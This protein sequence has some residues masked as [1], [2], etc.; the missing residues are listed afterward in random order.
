[1]CRHFFQRLR[2]VD[3]GPPQSSGWRVCLRDPMR[4]PRSIPFLLQRSKAGKD[5]HQKEFF[6]EKQKRK[7]GSR[8]KRCSSEQIRCLSITGGKQKQRRELSDLKKGITSIF[9]A[10]VVMVIDWGNSGE[11]V[12]PTG[13]WT[14]MASPFPCPSPRSLAPRAKEASDWWDPTAA[15]R[16]PGVGKQW[17]IIQ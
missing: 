7:R 11:T 13:F 12:G 9:S 14:T 6:K 8:C 2:L 10:S 5:A 4:F 1:M 17:M 15:I 3:Q 16:D